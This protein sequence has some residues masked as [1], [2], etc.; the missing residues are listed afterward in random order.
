MVGL[1]AIAA[2]HERLFPGSLMVTRHFLKHRVNHTDEEMHMFV[3]AR[4]ESVDESHCTD[5]R[6]VLVKPKV[7]AADRSRLIA[8]WSAIATNRQ[9][10]APRPL[11]SQLAATCG[12][13]CQQSGT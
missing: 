12:Q 2:S 8:G 3:Q 9:K 5:V 7:G 11:V 13:Q 4:V 10:A 6:G 1:A